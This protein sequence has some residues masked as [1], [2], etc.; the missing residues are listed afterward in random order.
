MG[1]E[2]NMR[3]GCVGPYII[4]EVGEWVA[5]IICGVGAWVSPYRIC[6]VVVDPYT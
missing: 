4:C 2:H 5:S 3:S 1:S 6:G